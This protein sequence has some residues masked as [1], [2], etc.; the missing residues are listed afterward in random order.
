MAGGLKLEDHYG[1]FQLRSFY[2][3][4]ILSENISTNCARANCLAV[5]KK[6]E[7]TTNFTEQL[8][9]TSY[10]YVKIFYSVE[11]KY[12]R[13]IRAAINTNIPTNWK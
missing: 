9:G 1:P 6:A 13:P 3:S 2:D 4:V 11:A 12:P 8:Q 10:S 7:M 5:I